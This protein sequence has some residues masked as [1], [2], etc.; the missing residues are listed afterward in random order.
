MK[1][2]DSGLFKDAPSSGI[3]K[4]YQ[5]M[6]CK[7]QNPN[8][9]LNRAQKEENINKGKRSTVEVPTQT[10]KYMYKRPE[11]SICEEMQR[12]QTAEPR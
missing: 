2:L 9:L 3:L 11:N 4:V 1:A 6:I 5:S 10:K 8:L 7:N 12:R